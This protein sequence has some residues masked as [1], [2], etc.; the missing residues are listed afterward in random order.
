MVKGGLQHPHGE[1]CVGPGACAGRCRQLGP[2]CDMASTSQSVCSSSEAELPGAAVWCKGRVLYAEH[3]LG[4]PPRPDPST[5]TSYTLCNS[6]GTETPS[7]RCPVQGG[8]LYVRPRRAHN[9]VK[10]SFIKGGFMH[11]TATVRVL[12]A[13]QSK[14]TAQA[15]GSNPSFSDV[16]E[17]ILG[18]T[19]PPSSHAMPPHCAW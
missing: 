2:T 12:I 16:L 3:S 11:S 8:V 6:I 4:K 14:K 5:R 15:D 17:F 18:G 9:L 10:K 19:P 7:T 13:G 1:P